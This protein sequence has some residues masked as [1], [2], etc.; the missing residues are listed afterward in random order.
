M[1]IFLSSRRRLLLPNPLFALSQVIIK[2]FDEHEVFRKLSKGIGL[3]VNVSHGSFADPTMFLAKITGDFLDSDE[4]YMTMYEVYLEEM[5]TGRLKN[6]EDAL[7][8]YMNLKQR[9]DIPP[10]LTRNIHAG[11]MN[12][13]VFENQIAA[14]YAPGTPYQVAGRPQKS[15]CGIIP[16][17]RFSHV[18]MGDKDLYV[19]L[20]RKENQ[21]TTASMSWASHKAS[22]FCSTMAVISGIAIFNLFS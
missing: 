6:S 18:G 11:K 20:A 8:V 7:K 2:V 15:S 19:A 10:S 1:L 16:P 21:D 4:A 9:R 22:G 17:N 14:I 3:A 5:K 12:V 13:S